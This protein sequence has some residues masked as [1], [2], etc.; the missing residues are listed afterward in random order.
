[1]KRQTTG[2]INW[3]VNVYKGVRELSNLVVFFSAETIKLILGQSEKL[4]K[5]PRVSPKI[6]TICKPCKQ[7]KYNNGILLIT[8][9]NKSGA[10][11]YVQHA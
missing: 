1:M 10:R 11:K 5:V 9:N 8:I 7:Q 3:L 2:E 4:M 6:L